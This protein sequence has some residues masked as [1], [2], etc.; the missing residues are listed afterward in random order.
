[1]AKDKKAVEA[2]QSVPGFPAWQQTPATYIAG[3]EEIDELDLVAAEMERKWGVDRLRQLVS[4][5][6]REKFDRQ[7]YKVAHVTQSSGDVMDVRTECRRMITAW[8]ALDAAAEAAGASR[9]DPEV[10]E[11]AGRTGAVYAIVRTTGDARR[12][13]ASKRFVH[14]YSLDEIANLIDN[15]PEVAKIKQTFPGAAVVKSR[16]WIDDPLDGL[17]NAKTPLDDPIPF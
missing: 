4:K 13:V 9:L 12:V 1:M 17:P 8:K 3:Q 6:L 11:V 7:R 16:S 5:E 10:W 14:V 2:P 15:F